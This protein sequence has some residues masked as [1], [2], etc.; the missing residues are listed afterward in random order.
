MTEVDAQAWSDAERWG[1]D[2]RIPL[3]PGFHWLRF[4]ADYLLGSPFWVAFELQAQPGHQYEVMGTLGC[5]ISFHHDYVQQYTVT[6]ADI[7]DGA[8]VQ[9]FELQ[10]ICSRSN[11]SRTCQ[12]DRDCSEDLN[13]VVVG[14]TGF[15]LCGHP[16]KKLIK[17]LQNRT[18]R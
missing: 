14:E 12:I 7:V 15:G 16:C 9:T 1:V 8:R 18:V 17:K 10:G 3:Q 6:V 11:H 4:E 13:C 2:N 5:Q